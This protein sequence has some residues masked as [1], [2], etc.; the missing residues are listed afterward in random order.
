MKALNRQIAAIHVEA[1][2]AGMDEDTRRAF[3]AR[4]CGKE[5]CAAMNYEQAHKVILALRRLPGM[6]KPA[7][8]RSATVS[9]KYAGLLRAMWLNGYNLGVLR[10]RDDKA[11]I[12]FAKRQTGLE[13]TQFLTDGAEV[14]KIIEA[15]K[16]ICA[17]EAGVDWAVD[18]PHG[19]ARTEA[20][21]R[22]VLA[23]QRRILGIYEAPKV[24][25]T[26]LNDEIARLGEL[27]R[28]QIRGG[29]K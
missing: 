25:A 19:K 16:A 24:I 17:R 18:A 20:L 29:Q 9:G 22:R 2:R 26:R 27:I 6:A 28:K 12:A 3:M 4:E 14:A 1:K 7:R 8:P 10:N 21:Q 23:A 11:L 13:H 5:S 15:I